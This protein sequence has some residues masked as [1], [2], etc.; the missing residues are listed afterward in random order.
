MSATPYSCV[1]GFFFFPLI[2]IS[3]SRRREKL[4]S[5][6]HHDWSSCPHSWGVTLFGFTAFHSLF[7]QVFHSWPLC[8]LSSISHIV[9]CGVRGKLGLRQTWT[10]ERT[11]CSHGLSAPIPCHSRAKECLVFPHQHLHQLTRATGERPPWS[12]RVLS[13]CWGQNWYQCLQETW[14]KTRRA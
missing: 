10:A 5:T 12:R 14:R 4:K 8:L 2:P 7:L 11:G 9:V 1:F 3:D 6:A 13:G